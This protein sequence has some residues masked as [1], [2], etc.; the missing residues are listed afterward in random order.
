MMSVIGLLLVV[1]IIVLA[2]FF[3]AIETKSN[4]FFIQKRIGKDGVAFNV[5]KIK[6]M[7]KIDGVVTNVSTEND[8]RITKSGSIFRRYKVDELPQLWNVFVGDM[9]FVGPRPDVPGYAD[10]LEGDDCIILSVRPGITG[11]ASLKYKNEEVILATQDDPVSYNDKV[12][13][14]DKVQ[15]NREYVFNYSFSKD[16]RYIIETIKG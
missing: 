16:L 1:P 12:I 8:V 2:W 9:S 11:P 6:T 14:P 13:W 4:G 7:K 5:Y 10:M 3:S 15:I